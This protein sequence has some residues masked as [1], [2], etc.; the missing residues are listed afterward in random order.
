M[1]VAVV[2]DALE[3][4][5][6]LGALEISG[7][8]GGTADDA[9]AAVAAGSNTGIEAP[10]PAPVSDTADEVVALLSAGATDVFCVRKV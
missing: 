3:L 8:C 4:P 9:R 6:L 1:G 10:V 7:V 2:A 5:M